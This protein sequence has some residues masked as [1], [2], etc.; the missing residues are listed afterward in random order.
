MKKGIDIYDVWQKGRLN[1][2]R[3]EMGIECKCP[4]CGVVLDPTRTQV[5]YAHYMSQGKQ[6]RAKHGDK[7]IDHK[8]NGCYVCDLECNNSVQID[9]QPEL[10]NELKLDI[11]NDILSRS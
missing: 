4:V 2:H 1:H 5:Q 7:Y 8:Y 11:D 10:I 9:R 6:S 3:I